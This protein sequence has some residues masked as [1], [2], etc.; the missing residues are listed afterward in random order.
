M[1]YREGTWVKAGLNVT[2]KIDFGEGLGVRSC[3]PMDLAELKDLPGNLRCREL[4]FF[5]AGVNWFFDSVILIWKALGLYKTSAGIDLGAR[6]LVWGSWKFTKPPNI[7]SVNV[8]VNGVYGGLKR[9]L[10]LTVEHEDSY[11]ATAM[12]VLPA[13]LGVVDGSLQ[14]PGVHVMGHVLDPERYLE[15]LWDMGMTVAL[16]GL[17]DLEPKVCR[18]IRLRMAG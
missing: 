4:G 7:C 12:A 14:H 10:K 8:T 16:Q 11:V 3:Y 6:L 17:Y 5:G 18:S 13:I 1:I 15:N 2:K 9:Q